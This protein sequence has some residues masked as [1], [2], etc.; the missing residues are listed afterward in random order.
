MK[1]LALEP[2]F[3]GSHQAFLDGWIRNSRHEWTSLTLPPYKWKWRMRHS[4]ITFADEIRARHERGQR[5][6]VLLCSD[7]V[8]LAEL[9]GLARGVLGEL[10]VVAYFHENQITYPVRHESERD[11]HFGLTNITTAKAAT[12]VWFN[13]AFHRD[14]FIGAIPEFVAHMPDQHP[15]DVDR[16]IAAKAS[17]QWPGIDAVGGERARG[18]GPLH[19]L[20]ASRWEHDKNP[21]LLFEALRRLRQRGV[22][23]RLSVIG[24]Q[25]REAPPIFA[26]AHDEYRDSIEHW[27]FQESR[28]AY[29]A[30][31]RGAD[32]FVSTA[33]HEFFGLSVV[34]A[35]SAGA[36]PLLPERLAYPEVLAACKAEPLGSFLY[37]GAPAGLADALVNAASRCAEG[38]LHD[39]CAALAGYA[40]RTFDWTARAAKLDQALANHASA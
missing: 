28:D 14:T 12:T 40:S 5:W 35:I 2:Y 33:S 27:G 29:E 19:I 22:A 31:L 7:M 16:E 23:F 34:E 24:E 1:V 18:D 3:G 13:S 4:A 36:F 17:V 15:R 30:A 10:P 8:N 6:D 39:A 9:L 38:K 20:W 32:V 11:Y 25:F 37:D 26:W 21:E